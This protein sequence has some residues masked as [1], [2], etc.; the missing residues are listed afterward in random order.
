MKIMYVEHDFPDVAH[1]WNENSDE[2]I[3][4]TGGGTIQITHSSLST[5]TY[6]H[7]IAMFMNMDPKKAVIQKIPVPE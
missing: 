6:T 5:D 7:Y 2:S 1:T 4:L 3:S